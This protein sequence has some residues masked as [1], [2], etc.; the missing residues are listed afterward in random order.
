MSAGAVTEMISQFA[1]YFQIFEESA[2]SRVVYNEMQARQFHTSYDPAARHPHDPAL[3]IEE[4]ET[5]P[6]PAQYQFSWPELPYIP[7]HGLLHE[8]LNV[9]IPDI[10]PFHSLRSRI[11]AG[12][13]I[14]ISPGAIGPDLIQVT[15]GCGGHQVALDAHQFNKLLD[16]DLV[17]AGGSDVAFL[18][19]FDPSGEAME[20]RA[21]ASG[22]TPDDL[23]LPGYATQ[24]VTVFVK[25]HDDAWAQEHHPHGG[26][27]AS[28][29]YVN[30]V[31]Q[32]EGAEL[33]ET[34]ERV[35]TEYDTSIPG[36]IASMGDNLAVNA[37]LISDIG[38]TMGTLFVGGD[39]FST[40]AIVQTN[41]WSDS[42]R[43]AYA[44][45][46]YDAIE[47]HGNQAYNVASFY[48]TGTSFDDIELEEGQDFFAGM[49]W[50][51]EVFEGDFYNVHSLQQQNWL[52]DND[53]AVQA[54]LESNYQLVAGSNEQGNFINF[55]SLAKTYDLVIVLGD[56]HQANLIYQTNILYDNDVVKAVGGG[57]GKAGEAGEGEEGAAK[58]VS[59]GG[60]WLLNDAY[61]EHVGSSEFGELDD[62]WMDLITLL[63][64]GS[65]TLDPEWGLGLPN[66]GDPTFNVLFITGDMYDISVISQFN[67]ILDS[68]LAIQY[69]P[70]NFAAGE[71]GFTQSV[72]TGG[73]ALVNLAAILDAGA[74]AETYV[75]GA[76]YA[77]EMLIQ[78]EIVISDDDEIVFGNPDELASELVAFTGPDV[79]EEPNDV[80]EGGGYVDLNQDL[81][82]NILT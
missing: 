52:V 81:L 4:F 13:P 40:D 77:D 37:A 36:Q 7:V 61:I 38:L 21:L 32:E 67:H 14:A 72:S 3:K 6:I 49:D 63:S 82:G 73:N 19:P 47:S 59:T 25:D 74:L 22:Q 60:N 29:D 16:S 55:L 70:G 31:L 24:V 65:T 10:D 53:I 17:L 45:G 11:D 42:D 20:M 71:D 33:P 50:F 48:Q 44:G 79:C 51:V 28:G 34:P 35:E 12:A 2:R 8:P 46:G 23:V 18:N 56:Y 62:H 69:L 57:Q 30:G 78:A 75:G 9:D 15:Y 76:Y 66:F 27:I 39:Y 26:E 54:N 5:Q 1:G 58:A 64:G 43:I 68:D 80:E 41:I